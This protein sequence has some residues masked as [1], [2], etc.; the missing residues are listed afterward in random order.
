MKLRITIC[1]IAV[2]FYCQNLHAQIGNEIKSFVDSTEVLINNG[3]K[4][5]VQKVLDGNY[6]KAREIYHYL[7]QETTDGKFAAFSYTEELY[8]DF[9]ISDWN[10]WIEKAEGFSK[11]SKV[12]C[13]QDTYQIESILYNEI[14][15][16]GDFFTSLIPTL[17]VDAEAKRV[18]EIYIYLLKTG[19]RDE[20]YSKLVK[21]YHTEYKESRFNDFFDRYLPKGLVKA[22]WSWTMGAC[23]LIPGGNLS[24]H[25]SSNIGFSMAMDVNVGKIYTSLNIDAGGLNLKTPFSAT[26]SNETWNF[27]KGEQFRYFQGGVSVGYFITRNNRCHL[28]PFVSIGGV[29][30]ESDRYESD[31]DDKEF[32]I[33]NAFS[34]GPGLHTEIKLKQL[35]LGQSIYGNENGSGY[36]SLKLDLGYNF[37]TKARID[38]FKGNVTYFNFGLVWGIGNF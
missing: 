11:Y 35:K 8:L 5:L 27:E 31:D 10:Q 24:D 33:I 15:K 3:R 13:Y 18:M 12:G 22:S 37:I 6:D 26:T 14:S 2:F 4:M 1:F 9:L 25:F 16:K 7:R 20:N 36:F 21:A 34:C 29:E 28:A 17:D 19:K 32:K 23:E 30:L 38:D